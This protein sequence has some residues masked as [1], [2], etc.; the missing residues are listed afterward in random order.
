MSVTRSHSDKTRPLA[1][2][3]GLSLFLQGFF[4]L[5]MSHKI[6]SER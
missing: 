2:V 1:V 3:S 4:L 6:K 5:S